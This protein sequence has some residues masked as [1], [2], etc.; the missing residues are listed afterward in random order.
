M[1][2]FNKLKYKGVELVEDTSGAIFFMRSISVITSIENER[3][4]WIAELRI[5]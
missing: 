4:K 3:E 5:N 2:G 1:R